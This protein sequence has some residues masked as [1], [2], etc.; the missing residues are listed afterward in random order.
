MLMFRVVL[1][2][3]NWTEVPQIVEL[4][5][6]YNVDLLAMNTMDAKPHHN[7]ATYKRT[8]PHLEH[9]RHNAAFLDLLA[10]TIKCNQGGKPIVRIL[11]AAGRL[12]SLSKRGIT[13]VSTQKL[14]ASTV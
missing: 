14:A 4:G 1:N 5:R 10:E 9:N 6:K 13:T 7:D 11:D 8:A 12:R 2:D 3:M